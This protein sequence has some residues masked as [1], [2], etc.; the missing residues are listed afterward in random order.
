MRHQKLS[1]L[2]WA[3]AL[4]VAGLAAPVQAQ[5][6]QAAVAVASD[7][8]Q[9]GASQSQG[10]P[11]W[12]LD[13]SRT[14]DDTGLAAAAGLAGPVLQGQGGKAELNL[15]L[16]KP[17]QLDADWSVL[18]SATHYAYLGAAAAR[19]YRYQEAAVALAWRGQVS[20]GFSASPHTTVFVPG[21]GLRSGPAQAADLGLH[22]RL[23]GALALDLG[24]GW[25]GLAPRLGRSFRYG[26]AGLSWRQ[27]P[28]HLFLTTTESRAPASQ[29]P[30]SAPERRRCVGSVAWQ[31]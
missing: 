10:R 20:A 28:L 22:Q 3:A 2:V 4:A 19:A 16:G 21:A 24:V 17:W 1:T 5:S 31:F 30:A 12:L 15:S 29:L 13:L 9:R 14:F 11:V 25:R 27:G 23:A 26:S 6:W 18:A 8:V 7:K